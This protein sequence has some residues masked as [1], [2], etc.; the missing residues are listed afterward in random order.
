MHLVTSLLPVLTHSA[1]LAQATPPEIPTA[2]AAGFGIAG[3]LMIVVGLVSLVIWIM[4]LIKQFQ[5]DP[6]WH[7]I[8]GI[9]TCGLYTYIWGWINST[10]LNLK[11]MMLIWTA[12][13]VV[14]LGLNI[15]A[16][17][18][19]FGLGARTMQQQIEMQKSN[20]PPAQ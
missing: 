2:A 12:C 7:G 8:V 11:K 15:V 13:I 4:M 14:N 1:A 3:L 19:A 17:A 10:R 6:A 18:A 5:N 9:V 20:N 16:G